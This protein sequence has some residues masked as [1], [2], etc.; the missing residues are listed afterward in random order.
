MRAISYATHIHTGARSLHCLLVLPRTAWRLPVG[1]AIAT[2]YVHTSVGL[3]G[4]GLCGLSPCLLG[5]TATMPDLALLCATLSFLAGPLDRPLCAAS[6]YR[7]YVVPSAAFST[8]VSS[9]C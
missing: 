4:G 2:V 5:F 7:S 1:R 9:V 8:I 6:R 3:G